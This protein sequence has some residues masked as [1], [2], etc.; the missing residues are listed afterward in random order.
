MT[1]KRRKVL[2]ILLQSNEPISAYEVSDRF[3]S[4]FDESLSAMSAYRMLDFLQ[5]NDLVHK[6][7]TTNQ[8]LACSHITC[9]HQH[10]VPQFLICDRCH[11]VKEVGLRKSLL[12]ELENSIGQTGFKLSSQQLE[13]RGLCKN[14]Q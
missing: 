10:R 6:L 5:E 9:E 13:L 8:Y 11:T 7:E 3:K 12:D 14:C 2:Q 1:E 4:N